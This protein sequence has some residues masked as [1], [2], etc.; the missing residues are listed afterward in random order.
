M[1]EL[2]EDRIDFSNKEI[3]ANEPET[4]EEAF[5]CRFCG[6]IKVEHCSCDK[7]ENQYNGEE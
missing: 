7:P 2:L 3:V 5:Y 4:N 6:A 1:K